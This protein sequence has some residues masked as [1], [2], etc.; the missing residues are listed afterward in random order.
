MS[1]LSSALTI[2]DRR[3]RTAPATLARPLR[4]PPADDRPGTMYSRSAEHFA[5]AFGRAYDA[6]LVTDPGWEHFWSTQRQGMI[7]VARQGR[8]LF[9]G[10]GLLA[11]AAHHE[12]LLRQFVASAAGRGDT[13]TFF[14]IC[15]DQL[16]LFRKFGFQATKWGEEAVVDLPQ[17]T[18]SGKSYEWVRRQTNYCRRHGLEFLECLPENFSPAQ[19]TRLTAEL[20]EVSRLF[21]E[22]KP[23]SREMRFLQGTFDPG[24]LGKKRIFCAH[25]CESGRI[26]GFVACNPCGGRTWVMETYRQR[27]D[28]VRGTT[29]FIMHQAM[30][31]F[32][33][34][35][36]DR[37]SLCLLPGLRC[38]TRLPGDS[39]M[40]RWG[41]AIGTGGIN[42]AFETAGA[43]HFKSRF[44][45]RFESRYLC[46]RPR[47]TLATAIAF[48]R[49]QGVMNLDPRKLARLAWERWRNRASRATLRTPE[50]E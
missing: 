10:G 43:Y 17:C 27:P 28:A 30:Q 35:G 6:Y 16:P 19:W 18:W 2:T 22:A 20:A 26:E 31:Q 4:L 50:G 25:N 47:M 41:L 9:S 3:L 23:H 15:E 39:T 36:V 12:D 24:R 34:E 13:L 45:P 1:V 14:N 37:V 48:I 42:P 40:V 7:A 5:A 44:R 8:H 46:V 38:A 49:L 32:K 29:A 11:P 33:K 21:L